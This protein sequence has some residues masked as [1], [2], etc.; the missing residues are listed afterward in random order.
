MFQ[1]VSAV[2]DRFSLLA[3]QQTYQFL[4]LG[5][6]GA[7]KT[8]FL[9]KL[10]INGY[11]KDDVKQD[12]KFLKKE[13]QD[14]GYHFEEFSS[15]TIGQYGI[16]EVPGDDVMR[17]SWPMFYR[18]LRIH[19]VIFVVDAFSPDCC[20]LTKEN[21]HRLSKAREALFRL[22]HEDELRISVFFLVL[23]VDRNTEDAARKEDEEQNDNALFQ[24]MGVPE[25]EQMAHMKKRFRKVVLN[26]AN[27]SRKDS[28]WENM[29]KEFRKMQVQIEGEL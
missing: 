1:C 26:C 8:T 17:P 23:N 24:M 9:Y 10:K 19:G 6:E 22:L 27:I 20:A 15:P 29:L 14:L 21:F 3:G 28:N 11:K 12:M 16:W 13:R 2:S 18:Y 5:L 7:G 25:I 4:M